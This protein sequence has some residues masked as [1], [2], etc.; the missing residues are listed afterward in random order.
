MNIWSCEEC[1]E[2][3]DVSYEELAESGTPL[4]LQCDIELTPLDEQGVIEQ[5]NERAR[6]QILD[7]IEFI[8]NKSLKDG[9]RRK[10]S[11]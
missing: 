1:G 6:N 4:C 11:K 8:K 5:L 3:V 2:V 9:D 7:Y 10:K